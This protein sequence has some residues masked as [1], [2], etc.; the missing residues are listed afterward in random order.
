M[1][2][3]KFF[4]LLKAVDISSIDVEYYYVYEDPLFYDYIIK[5]K[6]RFI[7]F[8]A[9][10]ENNQARY[11]VLDKLD[12]W[13]EKNPIDIFEKSVVKIIEVDGQ[14]WF[15]E[16]MPY[17]SDLGKLS[18]DDCLLMDQQ[19]KKLNEHILPFKQQLTKEEQLSYNKI[20]FD[21]TPSYMMPSTDSILFEYGDI[22]RCFDCNRIKKTDTGFKFTGYQAFLFY[23]KNF[24]V[25]VILMM[26]MLSDTYKEKETKL[27]KFNE[28]ELQTLLVS[29]EVHKS[30]TDH[31]ADQIYKNAEDF[32]KNLTDIER[33]ICKK[34][35]S[36]DQQDLLVSTLLNS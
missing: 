13:L 7:N 36:R 14:L 6:D 24:N 9:I 12:K 32:A 10:T 27:E 17:Y 4:K 29:I 26:S 23:Y 20:I 21:Y 18:Y 1:E 3:L 5:V 33:I 11:T 30:R 22:F 16:N 31:Y 19:I 2:K 35:P 28:N 8:C 15:Y 25:S 34:L